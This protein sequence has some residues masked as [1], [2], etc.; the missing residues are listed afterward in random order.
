MKIWKH[1]AVNPEG[2][3]PWSREDIKTLEFHS[4]SRSRRLCKE[5]VPSDTSL[6]CTSLFSVL[7]RMDMHGFTLVFIYIYIYI[8]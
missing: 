1:E 5:P 3:E 6:C 8:I 2:A 4:K 7:L